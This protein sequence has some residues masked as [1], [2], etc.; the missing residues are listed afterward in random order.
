M[1]LP[2]TMRPVTEPEVELALESE[3]EP[4]VVL[5]E[6]V[7]AV[8]GELK[9]GE[10]VTPLKAE[11]YVYVLFCLSTTTVINVYLVGSTDK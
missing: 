1:V 11:E 7:E 6:T 4:L 5:P 2:E 3:V 8:V 9:T 10:I